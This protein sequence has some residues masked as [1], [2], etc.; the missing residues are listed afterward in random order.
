MEIP[1]TQVMM[2]MASPTVGTDAPAVTTL[3]GPMET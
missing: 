1:P 2:G 3:P